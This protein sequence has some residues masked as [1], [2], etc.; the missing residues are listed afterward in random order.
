MLHHNINCG[1]GLVNGVRYIIVGFK[2][3]GTTNNKRKP[4]EMP[5]EVY[6]TFFV[7]YVGGL[8]KVII[9]SGEQEVVPIEAISACFY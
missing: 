3:P 7:P 9:A 1:D 2:W 4:C 8:S 6:V 5:T